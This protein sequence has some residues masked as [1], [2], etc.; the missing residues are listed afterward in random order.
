MAEES[1]GVQLEESENAQ[2]EKYMNMQDQATL[3]E[4][5]GKK[6]MLGGETD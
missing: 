2:G 6:A 4:H 3:N 5:A 1:D